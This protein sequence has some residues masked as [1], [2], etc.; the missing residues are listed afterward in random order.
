MGKD[1]CVDVEH[2]RRGR[3]R[4]SP[5]KSYKIAEPAS[6]VALFTL[7]S[8]DITHELPFGSIAAA[9]E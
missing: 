1:D 6:A 3:P 2:K 4:S 8:T 9:A 5:E 7:A